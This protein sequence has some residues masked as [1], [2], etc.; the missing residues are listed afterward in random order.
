LDNGGSVAA[1][2]K[3]AEALGADELALQ[4]TDVRIVFFAGGEAGTQ[5]SWLYVREWLGRGPQHPQGPVY[6]VNAEWL[7][8]GPALHYFVSDRFVLR[9]YDASGP[10][11]RALDRASRRATQ[12]G[13]VP[14]AGPV[15]T[16]ARSFLAQGIPA[17]CIT[18]GSGKATSLTGLHSA[19]DER[20]R[21]DADA[22]E[23]SVEFFKAALQEIDRT[24]PS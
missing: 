24:A 6:F 18:S 14:D 2:L 15:S 21:L 12:H 11:M 23:R 20:Q 16:D 19:S 1:L 4:R 17:V 9:R 3:V 22:L 10:L 13:L 8:A 5:G 7:G